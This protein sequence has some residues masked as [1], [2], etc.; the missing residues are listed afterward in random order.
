MWSGRW[1]ASSFD[2]CIQSEQVS[3]YLKTGPGFLQAA[4]C[5]ENPALFA[6][7]WCFEASR[8]HL[9][10]YVAFRSIRRRLAACLGTFC[11]GK[12]GQLNGYDEQQTSKVVINFVREL[13]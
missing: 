8:V 2:G 6:T 13:R 9:L 10:R 3:G 5:V 4:L 11:G 1:S 12:L 7:G